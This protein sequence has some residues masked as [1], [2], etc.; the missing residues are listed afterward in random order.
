MTLAWQHPSVVDASV[1]LATVLGD[2]PGEAPE[3]AAAS[4]VDVDVAVDGAPAGHAVAAEF[5]SADDL[6]G[7]PLSAD[8]RV[9]QEPGV[10]FKERSAA[11][12]AALG[13]GVLL[14]L[15]GAVDAVMIGSIARVF[16]RY[17][18]AT[19][20]CFCGDATDA[21]TSIHTNRN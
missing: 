10:G 19:A 3:G 1:S 21:S 11:S 20:L 15:G 14:R 8:L 16:A 6:L 5:G 9:H 4:A 13:R 12:W 2:D 7:A 18:G 17:G